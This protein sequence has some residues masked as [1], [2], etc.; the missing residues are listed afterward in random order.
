MAKKMTKT[1]AMRLLDQH[2]INYQVFDYSDTDA[3]SGTDVADVLNQ[4]YDH[5]FKTL[6]CVGA[7]KNHFVFIVPV[8]KELDLK[9]AAKAVNEKNVEMVKSKDLFNLTG[10]VHGGCSPLAMKKTFVTV[11]DSSVEK[12]ENFCISGGKIGLQ[13][14]LKLSDLEKCL[15]IEIV[16]ISKV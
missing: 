2:K 7:S 9:Q 13:I 5:V 11:I 10:Y 14:Q 3:I 16:S 4:S 8:D 15:P 6:V 1:N 12:C